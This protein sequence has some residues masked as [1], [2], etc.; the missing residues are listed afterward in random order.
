M[1]AVPRIERR[2]IIESP[3]RAPDPD[4]LA[5]NLRYLRTAMRDCVVNW[6]ES[7]YASHALLTQDGVLRDDL[8][9]ERELGIMAGF[10]WRQ[11]AD[12]T[13]FYVD[14]GWSPGMQLALRDCGE[15]NM[16]YMIRELGPRWD[17][18]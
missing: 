1:T 13:V 4:A 10:A 18:A 2:V 11:V 3:Y 14:L 12:A 5:R 16:P 6:R 8:L 17:R 7:P 15:R 9:A